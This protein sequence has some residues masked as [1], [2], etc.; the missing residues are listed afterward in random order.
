MGISAFRPVCE[1][2]LAVK[3]LRT[4]NNGKFQS[5]WLYFFLPLSQWQYANMLSS[6][7]THVSEVQVC[8]CSAKKIATMVHLLD[9]QISPKENYKM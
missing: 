1:K 2:F 3:L 4:G 6:A 5:E 9:V 7:R 8:P